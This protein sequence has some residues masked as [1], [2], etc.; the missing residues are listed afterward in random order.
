MLHD[1]L[2]FKVQRKALIVALCQ[3]TYSAVDKQIYMKFNISSSCQ[4]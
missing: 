1:H 2:S 4:N 3:Y